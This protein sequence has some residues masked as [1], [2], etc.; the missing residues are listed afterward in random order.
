MGFSARSGYV[1]VAG[2]T[3]IISKTLPAGNYVLFARIEVLNAGWLHDVA[4]GG[5]AM[6]GDS[7]P[8]TGTR[9]D[10]YFN[11]DDSNTTITLTS[12]ISHAGGAIEMN[13]TEESGDFDVYSAS[14][15]AIK[16]DSL[17]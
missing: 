2:T 17:G 6:P 11:E 1:H 3:T 10:V 14:L 16:V 15:T 9:G 13:C 5:C 4:D 8:G 12:A 7:V